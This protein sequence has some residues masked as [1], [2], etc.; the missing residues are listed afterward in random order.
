MVELPAPSL[1]TLCPPVQGESDRVAPMRETG[2]RRRVVKAPVRGDS[3]RSNRIRDLGVPPRLLMLVE[4]VMDRG[5]DRCGAGT[6][7]FGRLASR[8]E[9]LTERDTHLGRSLPFVLLSRERVAAPGGREAKEQNMDGLVSAGR[10]G[11]GAIVPQRA[12]AR[13]AR[14]CCAPSRRIR[15][16]GLGSRPRLEKLKTEGQNAPAGR[17][18]S[19]RGPACAAWLA[20]EPRAHVLRARCRRGRIESSRAQYR[21]NPCARDFCS[22]PPHAA[23]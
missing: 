4:H 12:P 20:S 2:W 23:C 1:L 13:H 3:P 18:G 11:S 9:H 21:P 17:S 15:G 6:T 14:W 16:K 8:D 19:V 10:V 22:A 5:E 7:P